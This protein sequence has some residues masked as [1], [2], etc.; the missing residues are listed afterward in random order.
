MKLKL[1]SVIALIALAGCKQNESKSSELAGEV[2]DS[3]SLHND[4]S[5]RPKAA[6][7][8]TA[9]IEGNS[10]DALR[11]AKAIEKTT[12][13]LGGYVAQS[14]IK[15]TPSSTYREAINNDSLLVSTLYDVSSNLQ[16][17]IPTEQLD[18]ALLKIESTL[19]QVNYRITKTEEVSLSKYREEL[20]R[21]NALHQ[22]SRLTTKSDKGQ[23]RK[24]DVPEV[25]QSRFDAQEKADD[26]LVSLYNWSDQ[27]ELSTVEITIDQPSILVRNRE[28]NT[29]LSQLSGVPFTT[30][31]NQSL[32]TGWSTFESVLL[33]ITQFWSIVFLLVLFYILYKRFVPLQNEKSNESI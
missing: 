14:E 11:S 19:K 3:T 1:L 20:R 23:F 4:N 2:A 32:K 17:K 18:L 25:E 33:W 5:E 13:E 28:V 12:V 21:K 9:Q 10:E 31:L 24:K 7:K 29:E 15:K 27:I 6:W 30:K 26:A 22:A 8:R 16:L